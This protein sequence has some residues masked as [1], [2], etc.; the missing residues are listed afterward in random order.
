MDMKILFRVGFLQNGFNEIRKI[1][2]KNNTST[3]DN[4]GI[5]SLFPV[6]GQGHKQL[7][8]TYRA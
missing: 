4:K 6:N 3:N 7:T 5:I 8:T 1:P 2:H